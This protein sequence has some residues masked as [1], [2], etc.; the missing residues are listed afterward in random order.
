LKPQ[1]LT[2]RPGEVA[3]RVVVVGDPARAKMVAEEFLEEARLVSENRALY[4]YT[5][6]YRGV[7][8]SVAVHGI[9]G[10]SAA[11]VFEELRMLGA[12]AM[13][14]LGTAGGL[15]REVDVGHAVVV[16]GAAYYC[17]GVLGVYTPN[18]CMPTAPDPE[19]TVKL[20]ETARRAGLTVH[21]GPVVSNDAFYAESPDFAEFWS[22]RGV[23]AVEM[24]C[25]TLFALGWMRGFKTAALVVIAD[26][27][28]VPEK[29]NL[30]HHEQLAPVMRKAAKAVLD[31]L[32][33]VSV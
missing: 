25:A 11:I 6:R 10:P 30:L 31:A 32:V 8:V 12:R 9:G 5:G 4:V 24:E 14:R 2:A 33:E 19:L 16:T 15:R 27:L 29:K 23:I 1:H 18:A 22:K 20:A 21:M 7:P 17:G 13:V 28:V 3:E 26:N